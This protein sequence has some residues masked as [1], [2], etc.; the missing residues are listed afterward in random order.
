MTSI[1]KVQKSKSY[2]ATCVSKT[3]NLL[4][5]CG[6]GEA[7]LTLCW[8]VTKLHQ[9]VTTQCC[10]G[11]SLLKQTTLRAIISGLHIW[12]QWAGSS[13]LTDRSVITSNEHSSVSL[14]P[15]NE[16][17]AIFSPLRT[18]AVLIGLQCLHVMRYGN[19]A[20]GQRGE[21]IC[22]FFT[23]RQM[24]LEGGG[25]GGGEK[26]EEDSTVIY[27]NRGQEGHLSYLNAELM[28]LLSGHG[29]RNPKQKMQA[30]SCR[31]KAIRWFSFS[32]GY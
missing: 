3:F 30:E 4:Q 18:R 32:E 24:M 9:A 7:C 8:P 12:D 16:E 1:N 26:R 25:G 29:T 28:I 20:H 23:P 15:T 5:H 27:D 19:C 10:G 14:H 11:A 31:V 6:D 22:M 2:Y 21:A 17:C 13:Q